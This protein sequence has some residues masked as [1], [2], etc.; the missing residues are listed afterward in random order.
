MGASMLD[1]LAPQQR[2]PGP[3]AATAAVSWGRAISAD[4]IVGGAPLQGDNGSAGAWVD[5]ESSSEVR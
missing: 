2:A 5:D 3:S 1:S 4:P